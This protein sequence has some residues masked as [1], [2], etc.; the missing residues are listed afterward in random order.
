MGFA[1]ESAAATCT[2]LH[3]GGAEVCLQHPSFPPSP[4]APVGPPPAGAASSLCQRSRLRFPER[5]PPCIPFLHTHTPA[6]HSLPAPTRPVFIRVLV[7]ALWQLLAT[8]TSRGPLCC[9]IS[10]GRAGRRARAG[11]CSPPFQRRT[12][13]SR[14]PLRRLIR[15]PHAHL[16]SASPATTVTSYF[17]HPL[18]I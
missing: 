3:E 7:R 12:A 8:P 17:N 4:A 13:V 15:T 18:S 10:G 16:P 1:S 9:C 6:L 14:L 11:R 2:S 5:L